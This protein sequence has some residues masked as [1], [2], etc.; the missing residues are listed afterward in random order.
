MRHEWHPSSFT[1]N[2]NINL[3]EIRNINLIELVQYDL[4]NKDSKDVNEIYITLKNP[5]LSSLNQTQNCF[6]IEFVSIYKYSCI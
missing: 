4:K 1:P 6:K 2:H 5:L 3:L